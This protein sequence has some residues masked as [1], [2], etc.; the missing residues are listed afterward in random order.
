MNASSDVGQ[1]F[2]PYIRVPGASHF[3]DLAESRSGT[4]RALL[5]S[6]TVEQVRS[7]IGAIDRSEMKNLPL[8][9]RGQIQESKGLLGRRIVSML[10]AYERLLTHRAHADVREALDTVFRPVGAWV[11]GQHVITSPALLVVQSILYS[12]CEWFHEHLWEANSAV[13]AYR[14]LRGAVSEQ[15]A[16]VADAHARF[17]AAIIAHQT[18][19]RAAWSSGEDDPREVYAFCDGKW[20]D[21]EFEERERSREWADEA[22][23]LALAGTLFPFLRDQ[24]VD[25]VREA[26][27][28]KRQLA[29]GLVLHSLC[30]SCRHR[31]GESGNI[32]TIKEQALRSFDNLLAPERPHKP[33]LAY[34]Q[35]GRY[36]HASDACQPG[37]DLLKEARECVL[38]NGG[39]GTRNYMFVF[40]RVSSKRVWRG[41]RLEDGYF[42]P[43]VWTG[44]NAEGAADIYEAVRNTVGD[45]VVFRLHDPVYTCSL[46]GLGKSDE[47]RTGG[48]LG[49]LERRFA[50]VGKKHLKASGRYFPTGLVGH[51]L[52]AVR[53]CRP[54]DFTPVDIVARDVRTAVASAHRDEQFVLWLPKPERIDLAEDWK[55]TGIWSDLYDD[56]AAIL[57]ARYV[58]ALMI[59]FTVSYAPRELL[60]DFLSDEAGAQWRPLIEA[61]FRS[62]GGPLM[63]TY[64]EQV[65]SRR[66]ISVPSGDIDPWLIQAREDDPQTWARKAVSPVHIVG[67][68]VGGTAIKACDF[69]VTRGDDG[70][71][72]WEAKRQVRIRWNDLPTPATEGPLERARLLLEKVRDEVQAATM[73]AVGISL[74]APVMDD[75]PVGVSSVSAR[76]LDGRSIPD[77]ANS[78]VQKLHKIDFAAVAQDVFKGCERTLVLNDGEAD[79][80]ASGSALRV[81]REGATVVIK[82][83]TGAAFALYLNGEPVDVIAETA[84]AVLNL[85][86]TPQNKDADQRFQ[87]GQLSER[88]SK[89]KFRTLLTLL[90]GPD[91]EDDVASLL[92]GGLLEMSVAPA[93]AHKR[94]PAE[95]VELWSRQLES[96]VGGVLYLKVGSASC[97]DHLRAL[98]A[99]V[100]EPEVLVDLRDLYSQAL[101]EV[102]DRAQ[103]MLQDTSSGD[104]G[105]L[106]DVVGIKREYDALGESTKAAV[107]CAWLLGRWLADGIALAW[108]LFGAREVRLAGGPLSGKT[109]IFITLSARRALEEVYGFDLEAA[110]DALAANAQLLPARERF[111]GHGPREIKRLM[112]PFPPENPAEGGPKGAAMAAFGA[113]LAD[114]KLRQLRAC[115]SVVADHKVEPARP[116]GSFSAAEVEREVE[117]QEH[118]PKPWLLTDVDVA[119][120]LARESS[121]LALTRTADGNF[122]RWHA[123]PREGAVNA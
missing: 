11:G 4:V 27:I 34:L 111:A 86:C 61:A 35:Y 70:L 15:R 87:Q 14:E 42:E 17:I 80:R 71:P 106:R 91:L 50:E 3:L 38:R 88:C 84:K 75:V 32:G 2:D 39:G 23:G 93:A 28:G 22:V 47:K 109:G 26:S 120:M 64:V 99:I 112:L 118:T 103:R 59:G 33:H 100:S 52:R 104:T 76:L 44:T 96:S 122:T 43:I 56:K 113:Y 123:R 81:S 55:T 63:T 40:Q 65:R 79:I 114:L 1:R 83:G 8:V 121:A 119:D 53:D 115:R 89:K 51:V 12:H 77:I 5:L 67:I 108:E 101:R 45:G 69:E 62:N 21:E 107:Y 57:V 60:L 98:A 48:I 30:L 82:E 95:I 73:N 105:A 25:H 7:I 20:A 13:R 74:A 58:A 29:A 41:Q 85:R 49:E 92:I 54:R 94:E 18:L 68:D 66:A 116:D 37:V 19:L 97:L 9:L 46:L 102:Q 78:N 16:I 10:E 90:N 36:V 110:E 72:R 24:V 6:R 117:G 31:R